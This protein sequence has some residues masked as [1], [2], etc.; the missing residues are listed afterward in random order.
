MCFWPWEFNT[1]KMVISHFNL[2]YFLVVW[3]LKSNGR[4]IEW[5]VGKIYYPWIWHSL[6][7]FSRTLFFLYLFYVVL[8]II[9][10]VGG[11]YVIKQNYCHQIQLLFLLS[12]GGNLSIIIYL[13]MVGLKHVG[14]DFMIGQ[15]YRPQKVFCSSNYNIQLC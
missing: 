10:Q 6:F 1:S 9:T 2:F 7:H 15:N 8:F 13:M 11:N 14:S 4:K 3:N 12:W 5:K